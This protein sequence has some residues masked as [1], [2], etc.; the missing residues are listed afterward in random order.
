M[1]KRHKIFIAINL[2]AEIKKELGFYAE[3]Y[4]ELPAKWV[5]K[6]GLHITFV[7]LGDLTDVELADACE[8][9]KKIAEIHKSF[10][11]VLNKVA[12]GPPLRSGSGQA[13]MSPRF[14]WATGEKSEELSDLK[15]DLE[16]LLLE[17]ISFRPEG[18]G[19][20]PHIT[21]ARISEWE[22]RKIEPEER[23]EVDEHIDLTFSVESIEVME[24]ELTRLGPRYNIIES[25]NLKE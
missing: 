18:R 19:F 23:P 15:N 20:T 3:K 9:V 6:E 17:K 24:S 25:H 1:E 5:N 22:F 14:V 7:F 4:A 10:N 13:K 16:E 11:I 21:L 8:A 12:Y 2:P